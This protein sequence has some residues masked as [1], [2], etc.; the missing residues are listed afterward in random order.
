MAIRPIDESTQNAILRK[1]AQTL[2]NRPSEQGMKPSEIKRAFYEPIVDI[3]NSVVTEINRIVSEANEEINDS[4]NLSNNSLVEHKDNKENPHMVTKSQV[5][6]GNVDNTSDAD[7]PVSNAQLAVNASHVKLINDHKNDKSNPH[8][9]TKE[10]ITLGNVDNTSDV[11]KPVS[12]AQQQ[13]LSLHNESNTAHADIR[14]TLEALNN[15]HIED[16]A[17]LEASLD[18]KIQQLIN[19]APEAYNTLKEIADWIASDEEGTSALVNRVRTLENNK[20]DKVNGKSL[21]DNN[22]SND[23][24]QTL[25]LNSEARHSH[26]NKAL[27][28]SYTNSNDSIS[29]AISKSHSHNFN[30]SEIIALRVN[31]HAHIGITDHSSIIHT[32]ISSNSLVIFDK[33]VESLII[34]FQPVSENN[35][36]PEYAFQFQTGNT[37]PTK[38]QLP[39]GIK[40]INNFN[41]Q[42]DLETNKIYQVSVLNNIGVVVGVDK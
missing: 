21:S 5:G 15:K 14:K 27:L 1:S 34:N 40:W 42:T 41:F 3:N 25:T 33:D 30:D 2:P 37:L 26:N 12:I 10:Q 9:V 23:N 13:A 32:S 19:N 36:L 8:R 11:N 28:D 22:F 4:I 20:V 35:N 39:S 6:L 18:S 31:N 38:I 16:K 7:K 24:L 17:F 29:G